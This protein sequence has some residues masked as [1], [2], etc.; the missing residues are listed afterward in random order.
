MSATVCI[1]DGDPLARPTEHVLR[2]V[3]SGYVSL[4]AARRDYGVG[5][6]ARGRHFELDVEATAALRRQRAHKQA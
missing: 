4:E 6:H 5:I 3:T 2:D 1:N